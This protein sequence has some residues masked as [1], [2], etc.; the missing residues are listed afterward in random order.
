MLDV[1]PLEVELVRLDPIGLHEGRG[2]PQARDPQHHQHHQ[3]RHQ[4]APAGTEHLEDAGDR[5]Q[6]R[7]DHQ[8]LQHRQRGVHVGVGGA[9]DQRARR[10]EQVEAVEPEADPAD[11]Q[12][13]R[14]QPQQVRARARGEARAPGGQHQAALQDVDRRHQHQRARHQ[15]GGPAVEQP[16]ERE[17]EE[18]EA[19]VPS[20]QRVHLPEGGRVEVLEHR[21]P[22]AGG[23]GS[24]EEGDHRDHRQQQ[25]AHERLEDRAARQAQLVL[26]LPQHVGRRGAGRHREV[27]EQEH[28]HRRAQPQEEPAAH[29]EARGEDLREAHL[30]EPEPVGVE[31][32]RLPHQAEGHE[33]EQHPEPQAR[34]PDGDPTIAAGR[35]HM[36][37]VRSVLGSRR[38]AGLGPTAPQHENAPQPDPRATGRGRQPPAGVRRRRRREDP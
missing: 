23:A 22:R 6:H 29:G 38:L 17:H 16:P 26:Q 32:D 13:Q 31:R 12:E 1:G 33:A 37:H 36:G 7:Q 5:A 35:R 30:L 28:E 19:E 10:V 14:G 2:D 11:Q 24:R 9:E 8:P 3:P 34:A 21:R 18:V 20:E 4:E 27:H 15:R 25:A